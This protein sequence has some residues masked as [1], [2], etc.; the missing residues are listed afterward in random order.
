M[1]EDIEP[2]DSDEEKKYEVT[3]YKP[4]YKIEGWMKR[5]G[6][7]NIYPPKKR[8]KYPNKIETVVED[9]EF[10]K[11][12]EEIENGMTKDLPKPTLDQNDAVNMIKKA[13]DISKSNVLKV[14]PPPDR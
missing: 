4:E 13:K 14:A 12:L 8:S 6:T 9:E 7:L 3:V 2:W 1:E 11:T 5:N 10:I